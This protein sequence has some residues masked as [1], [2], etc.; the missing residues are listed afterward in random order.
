MTFAIINA[1]SV[2]LRTWR[3]ELKCSVHQESSNTLSRIN[4][5]VVYN[6]LSIQLYSEQFGFLIA[7]SNVDP[8]DDKYYS[9]DQTPQPHS[10]LSESQQ[11]TLKNIYAT[12]REH[13]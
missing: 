8:N 4:M 2:Y 5:C 1:A 7:D 6:Y 3:A 13:H 12:V 9:S 11:S 10:I